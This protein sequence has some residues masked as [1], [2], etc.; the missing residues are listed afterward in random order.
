[1]RFQSLFRKLL[2]IL[3]SNQSKR[4]LALIVPHVHTIF[5][6][7][8]RS[9]RA[10]ELIEIYPAHIVNYWMGHT[11]AVAMAHYRQTTGKAADKFYAQ[12][13]GIS[14]NT[15]VQKTVGKTVGE[16]AETGCSGVERVK[17]SI[18]ASPCNSSACNDWHESAKE[19]KNPKVAAQGLEP[20]TRGL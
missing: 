13:A 12:A 18:F 6:S 20:R 15:A 9:K 8:M 10:T 11:E 3:Y 16:P 19:A 4:Q 14:E 1:M 5:K 7:R 2:D 17:A